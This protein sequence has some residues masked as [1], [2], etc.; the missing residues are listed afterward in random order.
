MNNLQRLSKLIEQGKSIQKTVKHQIK[1]RNMSVSVDGTF[2]KWINEPIKC[3]TVDELSCKNWFLAVESFFKK[4]KLPGFIK[5][6][7]NDEDS[8]NFNCFSRQL[9]NLNDLYDIAEFL[10]NRK[11]VFKEKDIEKTILN[12]A[13][14]E[15][16]QQYLHSYSKVITYDNFKE[17]MKK[18][19]N[20]GYFNFSITWETND[21]SFNKIGTSILTIKGRK[22]LRYCNSWFLRGLNFL[23]KNFKEIISLIKLI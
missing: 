14:S 11:L 13:T 19:I 4:I 23:R 21:F 22:H 17:I 5:Q 8:G 6:Y 10:K 1:N 20:K 2:V 16:Y 15:K 3:S 9:E 7:Y 18:L 12:L